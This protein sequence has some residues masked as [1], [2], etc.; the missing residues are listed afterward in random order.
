[1]F[2]TMRLVK[3][4]E[5][6]RE[7]RK[8]NGNFTKDSQFITLRHEGWSRQAAVTRRPCAVGAGVGG[9]HPPDMDAGEGCREV[10]PTVRGAPPGMAP[11]RQAPPTSTVPVVCLRSPAA[12]VRG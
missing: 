6:K 4:R 9:T 10:V 5:R 11:R 1:M 2:Q 3:E 8:K 12:V 7:E